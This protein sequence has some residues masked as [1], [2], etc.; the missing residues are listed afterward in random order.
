MAGCGYSKTI[1]AVN[2][3]PDAPIYQ[4]ANIGIVGDYK[5]VIPAFQAKCAELL[6]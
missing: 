4:R 5:K 1:V 6:G 3:D 2:R